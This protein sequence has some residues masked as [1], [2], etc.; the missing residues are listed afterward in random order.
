MATCE[1]FLKIKIFF[2]ICQ[3]IS[4][5][6]TSVSIWGAFGAIGMTAGGHRLWSHRSFKAKWQL[7]LILA[8]FF[9]ISG[10]VSRSL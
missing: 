7:R 9:S 2:S 6:Q 4:F 8:V 3:I 5:F 1:Q 10:L